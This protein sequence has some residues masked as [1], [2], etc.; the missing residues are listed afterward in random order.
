MGLCRPLE[1]GIEEDEDDEGNAHPYGEDG[2]GDLGRSHHPYG[3]G[4]PKADEEDQ[5]QTEDQGANGHMAITGTGGDGQ[6]GEGA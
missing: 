2:P 5:C 6:K 1:Q 4:S 3:V